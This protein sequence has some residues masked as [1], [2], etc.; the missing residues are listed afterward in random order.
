MNICACSWDD[1]RI[2]ITTHNTSD[3]AIQF[4]RSFRATCC[5]E[6]DQLIGIRI[7]FTDGTSAVWND[8][9][10]SELFYT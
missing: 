4:A 10:K 3:A 6:K 5:R 8:D 2:Q 7:N 1:G 9:Q